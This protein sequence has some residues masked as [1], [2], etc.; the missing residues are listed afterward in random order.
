MRGTL[1]V[2][3]GGILFLLGLVWTLQGLGYLEGSPMTGV[4]LWAV[5]GPILAGLGVGLAIVGLRGAGR[6]R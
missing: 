1:A 2:A 3:L 4:A 5:V 6:R